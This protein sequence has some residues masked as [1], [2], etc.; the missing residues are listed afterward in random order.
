M[1]RNPA[2]CTEIC[3][4]T[5]LIKI[6]TAKDQIELNVVLKNPTKDTLWFWSTSCWSP[7][8]RLVFDK[9][10]FQDLFRIYCEEN[11]PEVNT[12]L[13]GQELE[14]P[15]TLQ[16]KRRTNWLKMGFKLAKAEQYYSRND[17][18]YMDIP[19]NFMDKGKI[20]WADAVS[21]K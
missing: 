19:T 9:N 18:R 1:E 12:V 8:N 4:Q 13:P 14:I 3:L 2:K 5:E 20:I 6:N 11:I 16:I 21:L 15:I 10:K 17:I 7:Q